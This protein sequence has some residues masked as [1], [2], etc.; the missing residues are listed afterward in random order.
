MEEVNVSFIPDGDTIRL[1]DGRWVRFPG[2]DAPEIGHGDRPDNCG[3]IMSRDSLRDLI[4]GSRLFMKSSGMDRYGRVLG[5]LFLQDGTCIS[6][7]MIRMGMAWVYIHGKPDQNTEAWLQLQQEAIRMGEGIWSLLPDKSHSLTGNRRSYRFHQSDCSY[8]RKINTANRV[9]FPSLKSAF[10][11]GY[12][13][14]RECLPD[15]ICP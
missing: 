1:K 7:E 11:A 6:T 13:P 12:A 3:G 14:A 15:P 10:M 8:A 5:S 9:T 4:G 2:M